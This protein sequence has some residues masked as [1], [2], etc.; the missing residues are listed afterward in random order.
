MWAG[1]LTMHTDVFE[2]PHV[3]IQ[4]WTTSPPGPRGGRPGTVVLRDAPGGSVVAMHLFA[5]VYRID[6]EEVA[7]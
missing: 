7:D 6:R 1:D 2:A 5:D 4:M 3:S